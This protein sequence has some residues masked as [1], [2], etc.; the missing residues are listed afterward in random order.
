ML[1][2]TSECF[3]VLCDD[4]DLSIIKNDHLDDVASGAFNDLM[5]IKDAFPFL[6]G[7]KVIHCY[8]RSTNRDTFYSVIAAFFCGQHGFTADISLV[9]RI[10]QYKFTIK[11]VDTGLLAIK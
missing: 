5:K 4:F 9:I 1:P 8:L 10:G 11:H 7:Y 6:N 2:R 3:D